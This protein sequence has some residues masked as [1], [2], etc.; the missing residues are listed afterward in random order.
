MLKVYLHIQKEFGTVLGLQQAYIV[1][2]FFC[3]IA[4][5]CALDWSFEFK[6]MT[7]N[8]TDSDAFK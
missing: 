7:A 6:W 8:E 2:H 4:I 1:M 5:G 3:N